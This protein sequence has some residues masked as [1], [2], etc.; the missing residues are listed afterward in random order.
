M[1]A[2]V[3]RRTG[4]ESSSAYINV[5]LAQVDGKRVGWAL[6]QYHYTNGRGALVKY[7]SADLDYD[8]SSR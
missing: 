1:A 4:K 3:I 7:T 5:R 2:N 8:R 6:E